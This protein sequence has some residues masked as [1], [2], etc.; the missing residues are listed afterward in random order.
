MFKGF[1]H[2]EETKMKM[3][4]SQKGRK[5]T[6]GDKISKASKGKKC[7]EETKRK[8]SKAKRDRLLR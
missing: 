5:I 7:S 8:M 6:W 1:R 3:S 4:T 2:S